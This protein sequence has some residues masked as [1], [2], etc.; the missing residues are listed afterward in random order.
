MAVPTTSPPRPGD[1][2]G[3][4]RDEAAR[5]ERDLADPAAGLLELAAE[6]E[7][8][9]ASRPDEP[10]TARR[11]DRP[12]PPPL[13]PR[14]TSPARGG[15]RVGRFVV[16]AVAA[17]ALVAAIGWLVRGDDD[18]T[19]RVATGPAA[20]EGAPEPAPRPSERDRSSPSEPPASTPDDAPAAGAGAPEDQAEV[21]PGPAQGDDEQDEVP[22]PGDGSADSEVTGGDRACE[23]DALLDAVGG[24]V[25]G[26]TVTLVDHECDGDFALAWFRAVGEDPADVYVVLY[27]GEGPWD[28]RYAARSLDCAAIV[29]QV[30]GFPTAL[31]D[32]VP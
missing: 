18:G 31:C 3:R 24:S 14:A 13:P 23:P 21:A 12:P 17:V 4:P 22:A 32:T 6:I 19:D 27:R 20:G 2:I 1:A 29:G 16:L 10:A 26:R 30:Q 11:A 9:H 7:R 5:V 15:A 25:D 8:R 28:D